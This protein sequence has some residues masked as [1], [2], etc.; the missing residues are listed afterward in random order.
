MQSIV[1]NAVDPREQGVTMGALN[2]INSLMVVVAPSI[3]TPLLAQVGHLPP[4]DWRVGAPF[5]VCAVLQAIALF[6]A[7]RHFAL[8]RVARAR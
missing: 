6:L 3:G 1:S 2:S 4:A 5:Y 8:Q 7:R